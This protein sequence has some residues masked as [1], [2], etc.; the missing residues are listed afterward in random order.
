MV[1]VAILI[2]IVLLLLWGITLLRATRQESRAER[3]GPPSG[4]GIR[5]GGQL[6]Q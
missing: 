4:E 3:Q 5:I 2:G 1:R 6:G